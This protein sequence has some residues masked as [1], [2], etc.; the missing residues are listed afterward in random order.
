MTIWGIEVG[1]FGY[2][3][4]SLS[5]RTLLLTTNRNK[6]PFLLF[7][8]RGEYR[9]D[10]S[11]TRIVQRHKLLW[12]WIKESLLAQIFRFETHDPRS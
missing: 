12:K 10:P 4:F 9:S 1:P 5:T 6:R 3:E 11:S 7:A 2:L 8:I